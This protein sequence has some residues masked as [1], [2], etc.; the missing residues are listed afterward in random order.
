MKNTFI[1][2]LLLLSQFSFSQEEDWIKTEGE[3]TE[4]TF[5]RGK[6]VRESAIVKFNLED[7]TEQF[8]GVDL[9][10]I[11]FI[12]SMKSVGDSIAI[13][14]NRNNPYVLETVIGKLFSQYGMYVL[15]VLG[16]IFSIKPFLKRKKNQL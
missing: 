6:K 13:N 2:A 1:I 7:G 11:P 10:R 8:G 3:I 15:I 9:F 5:H 14:Y 16:I 4:I 12:G